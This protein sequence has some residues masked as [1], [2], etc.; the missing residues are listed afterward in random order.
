MRKAR[1]SLLVT[2]VLAAMA[3]AV[4][5]H[6]AEASGLIPSDS[7]HPAV[8]SSVQKPSATPATGEPDVG[9]NKV[10]PSSTSA[11]LTTLWGGDHS[12]RSVVD[13][14]TWISRIWAARHLGVGF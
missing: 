4:A 14:F 3:M 5:S 11:W 6:G 13:W 12:P 10:P 9:Q 2:L 7:G 8:V 1:N